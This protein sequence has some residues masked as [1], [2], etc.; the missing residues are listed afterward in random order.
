MAAP[1]P[2][3]TVVKKK[4]PV[5]KTPVKKPDVK[6]TTKPNKL[7]KLINEGAEGRR[8]PVQ[9]NNPKQLNFSY[10]EPKPQKT[11][12]PN[13][14]TTPRVINQSYTPGSA[15]RAVVPS[16]ATSANI[17]SSAGSKTL[18]F[19]RGVGSRAAGA[20]GA[21][22]DPTFISG[23]G[24]GKLNNDPVTKYLEDI[25]TMSAMNKKM[26]REIRQGP[27]LAVTG[28][29]EGVIGKTRSLRNRTG[30]NRPEYPTWKNKPKASESSSSA[31]IGLNKP[32]RWRED[33]SWK[34]NAP[35]GPKKKS[36]SSSTYSGYGGDFKMPKT[37]GNKSGVG[38]P[39]GARALTDVKAKKSGPS[40]TAATT[41][42][43]SSGGGSQAAGVAKK[44]SRSP[45]RYQRNELAMEQR[46]SPSG[47]PKKS[48][49]T[50]G[51]PKKSIL[52]LFRKG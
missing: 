6:K 31:Q 3:K 22:V 46:K 51:K 14:A 49:F 12:R 29:K 28:V 21:I 10:T 7:E 47:K 11:G 2:K 33:A 52:S 26:K 16:T 20:A 4:P 25:S 35:I 42:A 5:K 36:A 23:K 41:A 30:Q 38:G 18:A 34:Y 40:N 43:A 39:G 45:T 1:R 32:P 27:E 19:L 44:K 17:T 50:S 13:R 15:S 37:S 9:G 24:E 8:L 48:I